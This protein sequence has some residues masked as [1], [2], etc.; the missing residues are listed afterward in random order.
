M[1]FAQ[2]IQINGNRF[3]LT[4]IMNFNLLEL[5]YFKI[6]QIKNLRKDKLFQ[7]GFLIKILLILFI[8]PNITSN[9]FLPFLKNSIDI[10][11]LDPW[12]KFLLISENV[13]SFPYG[14]SMLI[15]YF[16]LSYIGN[17][18]DS[19]I[20]D[21]NLFEIGFK[22]SSLIFD[23]ILF[24]FISLLSKNK[25]PKILIISYW[26]SP[27]LIYSTYIH[28]QLDIVP[29][30]LLIISVYFLKTNKF[31]IAGFFILLSIL[32]KFSM[33]IALPF[34]FIYI[35]KRKG[36]SNEFY[37]FIISF[38][39]TFVLLLF[40]YLFSNGFWEMVLSTK[41]FNRLYTV[42]IP[43]GEELKLYVIPVIYILSL[44]LFWRLKRINQDL[45]LISLGIG[46][47]SIIVFLP[48]APAWTLWVI[49]F[50]SY[51]QINSKKD[52]IL[53]SFIYSFVYILNTYYFFDYSNI[54]LMNSSSFIKLYNQD[55]NQNLIKNIFFT[56][57]QGLGLLIA[58]RIYIYGL[59]KNSFFTISDNP[60]VMS[61]SGYD[62]KIINNLSFALQNLFN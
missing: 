42:F 32:S 37:K 14:L 34:M 3:M 52:V 48:P 33:L 19:Y 53:I 10:F 58:I 56:F 20:Y 15:A 62:S 24:V 36:I 21:I 25:S 17:I 38:L 46:F 6:Q 41:E 18:F 12:Q 7:I 11:S 28:G 13:N 60:I 43:Y 40:P 9:L 23:Y 50:L 35:I 29:I 39:I 30:T 2:N 51:Y 5:N 16:P 1:P 44:Y 54:E 61:I 27:I 26:L 22:F 49:P 8:T 31:Y 57:Q 55:I 47:L 59:K 4:N 45:F